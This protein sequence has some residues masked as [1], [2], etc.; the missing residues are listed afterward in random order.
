MLPSV[1]VVPKLRKDVVTLLT[2]VTLHN[3]RFILKS[4]LG[5]TPTSYEQSP[6]EFYTKLLEEDL[7][8][9]L[10]MLEAGICSSL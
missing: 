3:D 1:A 5:W 4:F 8:V 6:A 9:V 2:S 7:Q 10:E